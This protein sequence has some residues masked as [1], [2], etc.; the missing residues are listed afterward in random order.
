MPP[1]AGYK[2]QVNKYQR[3]V[4]QASFPRTPPITYSQNPNQVLKGQ[5]NQVHSLIATGDRDGLTY[6]GDLASSVIYN[7]KDIVIKARVPDYLY[8]PLYGRPR[9][10][11]IPEIRRLATTPTAGLCV[12]TITDYIGELEWEVRM[13]DEDASPKDDAIDEVTERIQNPNRNKE[14]FRSIRKK[15]VRDI[16][17]LDA[18]VT[19]KTFDFSSYVNGDPTQKLLPL[20]RRKMIEYWVYDGGTFTKSP[21]EHGILPDQQSYYQYSYHTYASPTPFARDEVIWMDRNPRTDNIYGIGAVE[22][23]YDVIRYEVFGVTS[24][25]DLFTRKNVPK[26]VL[27]V[28]DANRQNIR[29]FASRLKDKT[30]IV[31][32]NTDEARWSSENIPIINSE[33]KFINLELEPETMRLLESQQW[34]IKLVFACFGMT[35]VEAGF[36]EDSNRA[37]SIVESDTFK[38]KAI[39]PIADLIEEFYNRELIPEFGYDFLELKFIH[40]DIQEELRQ[41]K[42]WSMWLKNGQKTVNEYRKENGLDLVSWGDEPYSGSMFGGGDSSI[43]GSDDT[44]DKNISGDKI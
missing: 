28:I 38:R 39:F 35:P 19:V 24:G 40:E 20:G 41:E 26:G 23:A 37:N 18:G 32:E 7:P 27:S 14:T 5:I 22:M 42:L 29:E 43:F 16:L 36:T 34:Y 3:L 10:I 6:Q 1:A 11:N 21:D 25:I 15:L 2:S 44:S 17:C 9:N 31:D 30:M 13:K 8:R 4:N 33:A 12:Q